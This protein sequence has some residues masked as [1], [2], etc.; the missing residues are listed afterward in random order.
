MTPLAL[1]CAGILTLQFK[2]DYALLGM[3]IVLVFDGYIGMKYSD[4][5]KKIKLNVVEKFAAESWTQSAFNKDGKL[6]L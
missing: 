6:I 4:G 2:F 3:C 1:S 5:S